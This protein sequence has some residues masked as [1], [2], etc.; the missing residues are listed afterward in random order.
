MTLRK[1]I[2]AV[3]IAV[4]TLVAVP[5]AVGAD[6]AVTVMGSELASSSLAST[7][8]T[9][10]DVR[11]AVPLSAAATGAAFSTVTVTIAVL[12]VVPSLTV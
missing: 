6:K 9:S 5:P 2:P 11:P 10:G 8:S 4:V 12:V 1:L 3:F 7:S